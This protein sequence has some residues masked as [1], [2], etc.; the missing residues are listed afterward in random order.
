MGIVKKGLKLSSSV[1][2]ACIISFFLCISI[3]VICSA[4]FTDNI[5]YN[6]YVYTKD[7]QEPID[8]YQYLYTDK[9]GDGKDDLT[10]TKK[11]E[12]EKAG[13]TVTTYNM[14]S[15][16]E[17]TG[18]SVFLTITQILNGILIISFASSLVYKQGFKDANLARTGHIKTDNLKGFKI[19]TIANAPFLIL[20]ILL[21][22]FT[23]LVPNFRIIWYA[24]LNSH[25]YSIILWISDGADV[26]S[27]LNALQILL[28]LFGMGNHVVQKV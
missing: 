16:L 1:I 6:A 9:D 27:K 22:V 7:G 5:G 28:L 3:G 10:D 15:I 13:Y 2:V 23:N 20:F 24:Y 14:T 25:F 12:Y 21:L 4:V 19:G 26:A 11:T 17:G 18:K 8:E